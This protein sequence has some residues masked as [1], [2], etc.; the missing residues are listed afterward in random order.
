ML[1]LWIVGRGCIVVD[2][3]VM[4]QWL[5]ANC[6]S[7]YLL[8]MYTRG[9]LDESIISVTAVDDESP[10]CDLVISVAGFQKVYTVAEQVSDFARHKASLSPMEQ[11]CPDCLAQ[12]GELC[13]IDCSSNW[14]D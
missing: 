3:S 11:E 2:L 12:P 13:H 6:P 1:P 14:D 8:D 7:E 10:E 9:V 5:V 4:W